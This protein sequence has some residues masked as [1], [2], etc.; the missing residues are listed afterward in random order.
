MRKYLLYVLFTLIFISCKV[1]DFKLASPTASMSGSSKVTFDHTKFYNSSCVQCH[2]ENRP[3]TVP[4]HGNGGDCMSCHTPVPNSFGVRSWTNVTNFN[5]TP[6]P[7]T[8]MNCHENKRPLTSEP[9]KA[10]QWGAKQ[11]CV[12]CHTHPSWKPAKFDHVK[13]L[14]T[15]IECHRTVTKDDRPLPKTSH[16]SDF[17]NQI[18]CIQCHTNSTNNKKWTD[19][20][21]NHKTHSPTPTSCITCHEIKRPLSHTINPKISGMDKGDCKS[22]H[23]NTTDWKQAVAFNHETAQP[24]SCVGCHATSI[25]SNQPTHPSPVGNYSKI[26]CIKCHTY[27]QTTSAR[28]WKKLVFNHFTHTPAPTACIDCHKTVNDSR[29][30]SKSHM[31]GSRST[32]DCATCH[33]YDGVLLWTNFTPFNHIAIDAGERCDSCHNSSVKS[34]TSKPVNHINTTMDCKTCHSNS[35]WKPATFAHSATDTNCSSCHNGTNATGK[36]ATHVPTTQQCSVCHASQTAWKPATYVHAGT[37]TDCKSCHNGTT[38]TGRPA[39]HNLT[40]ANHQ[41]STCHNQTA[42][43]PHVFTTTYKHSASG[44]LPPKG[45]SYHKSQSTCTKCHSTTTDK[46]NFTNATYAPK[47]AACHSGDYSTNKHGGK[48]VSTNANCLSCH[49]YNG[50]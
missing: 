44:G 5:H 32:K 31:T 9:H 1:A 43:K 13:P 46:V 7:A 17:Y 39:T 40:L 25:P 50:W 26:D 16:P 14:T 6:A 3:S 42:F 36:T 27:D 28:S 22:C 48:A 8:C 45:T 23:T 4:P 35:A 30:T 20:T 47:C 24:T 33:K 21:F 10:G 49:S 41:C 29:P 19:V 38:A 2:E 12:S 18:D 15:C 37:D 34:L 11:D